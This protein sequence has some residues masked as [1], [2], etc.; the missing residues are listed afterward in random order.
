MFFKEKISKL[1]NSS[2]KEN[3]IQL[4]T[5]NCGKPNNPY[6]LKLSSIYSSKGK[7]HLERLKIILN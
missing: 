1:D 4:S 7:T 5:C 6:D 3:I 2:E